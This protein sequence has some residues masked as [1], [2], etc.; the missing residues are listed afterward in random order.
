MI[1]YCRYRD[2]HDEQFELHGYGHRELPPLVHIRQPTVFNPNIT[3]A[4]LMVMVE[5]IV[6]FTRVGYSN[7][8][9]EI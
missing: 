5:P 9:V 3:T 2:G 8:Y 4:E 1:V 7:D 6:T